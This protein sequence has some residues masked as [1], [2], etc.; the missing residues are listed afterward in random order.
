MG[1]RQRD[2]LEILPKKLKRPFFRI[3]CDMIALELL[4]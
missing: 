1:N 3:L 4:M 2:I